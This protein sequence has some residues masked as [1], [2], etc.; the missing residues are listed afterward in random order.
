M[1]ATVLLKLSLYTGDQRYWDIGEAAVNG[2]QNSMPQA[3]TN[4]GQ[5]LIAS[6]FILGEPRELAIVG[7]QSGKDTG[8]LMAAARSAYRPNLIVAV[9]AEEGGDVI[10]LLAQRPL[11]DGKATAYLCRRFICERPVTE[12]EKLEEILAAGVQ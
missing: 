12:A 8:E 3:P 2:M 6:S 5:W 11:L 1:A 7:K 9:G 10:Q 4:F